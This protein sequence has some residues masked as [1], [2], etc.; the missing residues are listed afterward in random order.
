LTQPAASHQIREAERRLGVTLF[1]RSG[2]WMDLTPAAERLLMAGLYAEDTLGKAELDAVEMHRNARPT[3]RIGVGNYD[4]INWLPAAVRAVEVVNPDAR[5]ELLRCSN[6]EL[7]NALATGDMDC[8]LAP[9][10]QAF[11]GLDCV[12][13]FDDELVAVFPA[14]ELAWPETVAAVDFAGW[15]YVAFQAHPS[16]GFEYERFFQAGGYIPGDIFRVETSTG[17]ISLV[18]AGMGASIVP[19]W[20]LPIEMNAGRLSVRRLAPEAIFITWGFYSQLK[21]PGAK[22]GLLAAIV[23]A[24]KL[25]PMATVVS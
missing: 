25:E 15:R 17:I 6:P 14:N 23:A 9:H 19:R 11:E 8:F 2:R 5:V 16:P 22:H 13:L 20:S 12:D 4:N 10:E 1:K 18:A 24:L 21:V 7:R 3:L